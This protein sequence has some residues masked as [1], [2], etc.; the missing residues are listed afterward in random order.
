MIVLI[1]VLMMKD[2]FFSRA[3]IFDHV[4]YIKTHDFQTSKNPHYRTLIR[5]TFAIVLV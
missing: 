3:I 5:E 4:D 2:D 1:V